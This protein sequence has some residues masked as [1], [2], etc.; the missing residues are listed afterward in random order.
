MRKQLTALL[1]AVGMTAAM[2]VAQKDRDHDRDDR[3]KNEHKAQAVRIVKG[4][5]VEWA[6]EKTAVIAWST[7]V[8]SSTTLRYGT[9]PNNLSEQ[10]TAPYEGP[11][12]RVRLANLTPSTKYYYR[13]DDTKG[14]GTGTSAQSQVY[15]FE[16]VAKGQKGKRYSFVKT[17]EK[18]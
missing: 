8:R 3:G 5:V 2:A 7:N 10:K 11:T 14:Q 13:L 4:P 15:E 18:H 1:L 12:H 9:N 17:N 16:T 6:G